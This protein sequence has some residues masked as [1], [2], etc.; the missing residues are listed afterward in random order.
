[1]LSINVMNFILV[2]RLFPSYNYVSI[3]VIFDEFYNLRAIDNLIY[4][5][6][7][8]NNLNTLSNTYTEH[9]CRR[10]IYL[11]I[12]IRK[13]Y[14]NKSRK[15]LILHVSVQSKIKN[16]NNPKKTKTNYKLH[17]YHFIFFDCVY[18]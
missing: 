16:V 3:N 8:E 10:H 5:S 17:R 2:Y 13:L 11:L 6:N 18:F 9:V 4:L 1:M 7:N 12:R 14:F 15:N